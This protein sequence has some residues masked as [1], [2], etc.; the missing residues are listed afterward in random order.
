[1]PRFLMSG[2][3]MSGFFTSGFVRIATRRLVARI[4]GINLPDVRFPCENFG[5]PSSTSSSRRSARSRPW[6]RSGL[7][8]ICRCSAGSNISTGGNPFPE[9]STGPFRFPWNVSARS[10]FVDR[11]DGWGSKPSTTRG[12]VAERT[13]PLV[14]SAPGLPASF[15]GANRPAAPGQPP[16]LSYNPAPVFGTRHGHRWAVPNVSKGRPS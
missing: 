1:M 6:C 16:P 2:F 5:A 4:S 15:G 12:P 8:R 9:Q 13:G 11:P 14:A 10:A 7:Q 3:L